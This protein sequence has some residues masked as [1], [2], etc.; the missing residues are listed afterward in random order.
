MSTTRNIVSSVIATLAF[1]TVVSEANAGVVNVAPLTSSAAA[2]ETPVV[3]VSSTFTSRY[4][5]NRRNIAKEAY[6]KDDPKG[7]WV[8]FVKHETTIGQRVINPALSVQKSYQK[9][10]VR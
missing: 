10:I 3:K 7:G 5:E 8:N 1:A 6:V 2:T 9:N 4:I